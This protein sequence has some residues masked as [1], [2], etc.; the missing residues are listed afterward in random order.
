LNQVRDENLQRPAHAAEPYG[1]ALQNVRLF[2]A[3]CIEDTRIEFCGLGDYP[4][5][6]PAD[7]PF[8]SFAH[9]RS[10]S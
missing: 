8:H 2:F 5:G 9:A 6:A 10:E 7:V 3:F 1:G 4:P